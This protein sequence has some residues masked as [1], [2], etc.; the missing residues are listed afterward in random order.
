MRRREF[1]GFVGGATLAWPLAAP[2]QQPDRCLRSGFRCRSFEDQMWPI[3]ARVG[4]PTVD[5]NWLL[6]C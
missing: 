1:I 4:R 3:A 6:D 5:Q 2:A